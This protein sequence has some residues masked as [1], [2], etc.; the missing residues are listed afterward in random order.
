VDTH[1][2]KKD[3]MTKPNKLLMPLLKEPIN[4]IR[5]IFDTKFNCKLFIESLEISFQNHKKSFP[6]YDPHFYLA[7][8]WLAYMSGRGENPYDPDLQMPAF[9]TTYL[10]ACVPPPLCARALGLFL[11][12]RERPE[13]F[14]KYKAFEE[15]FNQ[16]MLPVFEAIEN[17]TIEQ[18]YKKYNP[19]ME[20]INYTSKEEKSS[21]KKQQYMVSEE[22]YNKSMS[23]LKHHFGKEKDAD[24]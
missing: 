17:G 11:L 7:Q 24:K 4:F 3:Y 5:G 23:W 9:T 2:C 22:E 15:E 10:V 21:E 14:K 19:K 1:N 16:I 13:E 18:L 20:E 8:A 12:Y 6:D